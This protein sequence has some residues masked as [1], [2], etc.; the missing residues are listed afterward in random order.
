LHTENVSENDKIK[1]AVVAQLAKPAVEPSAVALL[2]KGFKYELLTWFG[3]FGGALTLFGHIS[4]V[5]TLADWARLLVQNW[6]EWTQTFWLWAFSSLGI[7]LPPE[8]APVLSFLLFGSLL[9]IGQAFQFN[10]TS[11][12][13]SNVGKYQETSFE[14]TFEG[15]RICFGAIISFWAATVSFVQLFA[16]PPYWVSG[17]L[18]LIIPQAII[19]LFARHR[20]HAAFTVFLLF[21]FFE[22]FVVIP[23]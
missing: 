18:S 7:H 13:Q 5:L 22:I 11:K 1:A 2:T 3:I 21:I 17:I 4:S 23:G 19:V 20:L 8:W 9:T 14:P 6:K 10:R 15:L 12:T 16:V